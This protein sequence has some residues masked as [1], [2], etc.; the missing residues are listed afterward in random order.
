MTSNQWDSRSASGF[1]TL[2]EDEMF[3]KNC[4]NPENYRSHP[5]QII[6][7]YGSIWEPFEDAERIRMYL[8]EPSNFDSDVRDLLAVDSELKTELLTDKVKKFDCLTLQHH[9]AEN[10]GSIRDFIQVWS[11]PN[12]EAIFN[13]SND[14]VCNKL[15]RVTHFYDKSETPFDYHVRISKIPKA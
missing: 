1:Y 2:I 7:R 15:L 8:Y 14:V 4:R 5:N 12:N 6:R 11:K 3:G 9:F 13:L 10:D